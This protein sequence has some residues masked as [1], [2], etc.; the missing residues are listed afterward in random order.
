MSRNNDVVLAGKTAAS[1]GSRANL[2]LGGGVAPTA[3]TAPDIGRCMLKFSDIVN[4]D[5]ETSEAFETIRHEDPHLRIREPTLLSRNNDIA[6]TGK[7]AASNGSLVHLLA[8]DVVSRTAPYLRHHVLQWSKTIHL[9]DKN[10]KAFLRLVDPYLRIRGYTII[11]PHI[12]TRYMGFIF[13]LCR[14]CSI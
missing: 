10:F 4:S 12:G 13:S 2:V 1:N 7:T 9:D 8:G 14:I 11:P 3:P 5:D 6:L